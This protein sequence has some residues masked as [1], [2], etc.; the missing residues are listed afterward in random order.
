MALDNISLSFEDAFSDTSTPKT[1]T[2][3]SP[4]VAGKTL[5]DGLP[6]EINIDRVHVVVADNPADPGNLAAEDEETMVRFLFARA[7]FVS[8]EWRVAGAREG[9]TEKRFFLVKS[10]AAADEAAVKAFIEGKGPLNPNDTDTNT[11]GKW[12]RLFFAKMTNGEKDS[13]MDAAHEKLTAMGTAAGG[14]SSTKETDRLSASR[15]GGDMVNEMKF[16]DYKQTLADKAHFTQSH[17][18]AHLGRA[19][20]STDS[21]VSLETS[22]Y[23]PA[24][25]SH[26][27]TPPAS[28][29]E[30]YRDN[31]GDSSGVAWFKK[32][33]AL[34]SDGYDLIQVPSTREYDPAQDVPKTWRDKLTENLTKFFEPKPE[35]PKLHFKR[36]P[37]SIP[38]RK[39]LL[40][41]QLFDSDSSDG[42]L[43]SNEKGRL[44]AALAARFSSQQ[45]SG[46]SIG[47]SAVSPTTPSRTA[48]ET[49]AKT[50]TALVPWR[51]LQGKKHVEDG[52]LSYGWI[53]CC[54]CM[55]ANHKAEFHCLTCGMHARCKNCLVAVPK[56]YADLLCEEEGDN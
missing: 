47:S 40:T 56:W 34:L 52:L 19:S 23:R 39:S 50:E 1:S 24:H 30:V 27:E 37:V 25:T 43:D 7:A 36:Q 9:E 5:V 46:M 8:K 17:S 4:K 54:N 55:G 15:F 51:L 28:A 42:S 16:S 53:V 33:I 38:S 14:P 21:I 48:Q 41:E 35:E 12:L 2:I 29:P 26:G 49:E 13:L 18:S 6:M 11:G 3:M 10:A 31:D 44:N 22:S 45:T 32:Y 20:W